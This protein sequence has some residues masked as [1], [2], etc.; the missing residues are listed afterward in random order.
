MR[1]SDWSSDV[2]SSDLIGGAVLRWTSWRG[3]FGVLAVL[4]LGLAVLG[5]LA[6]PET[7]PPERRRRGTVRSISRAYRDLLRDSTFVGLVGVAGFTLASL[8]AYVSGSSFVMQD[9][10]GLSEQ[11]FGFVFGAGAIFLIGGTQLSARLLRISNPD[12]ILM[13]S[14]MGAV[15]ASGLFLVAAVADR[16]EQ[17]TSALQSLMRISYA[18]FCLN[19]KTSQA[20]ST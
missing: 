14:L 20:Y 2:C 18:V 7:L 3:V 5:M 1:I 8:F 16:S 11:T 19:K 6:L 17:H 12:K 9:E 10:F 4:G 13:R 15:A